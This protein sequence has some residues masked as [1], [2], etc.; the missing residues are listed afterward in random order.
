VALVLA[1]VFVW[2]DRSP[3]AFAM[4]A[5]GVVLAVATIF[6]S[7]YPRVM[8]SSPDF[9]NSLTVSNDSSAHYTLAVMTVVALVLTPVVVLYQAW[10]YY[11][12]RARVTGEQVESP[13]ELLAHGQGESPAG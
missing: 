12:F 10:T 13:V 11:V 8:V 7:L 4:T 9:A 2:S 1:V 3:W 6:T 5:L